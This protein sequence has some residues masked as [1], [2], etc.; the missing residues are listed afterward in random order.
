V[1]VAEL[2]GPNAIVTLDGAAEQVALEL[3]EGVE[4]GD[5]LLCH[6]GVALEKLA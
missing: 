3:V 4:V 6:A 2:R 1:T 5:R